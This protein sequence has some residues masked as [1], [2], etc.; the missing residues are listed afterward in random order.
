MQVRISLLLWLL[1]YTNA[2]DSFPLPQVRI[3]PTLWFQVQISVAVWSLWFNKR[4]YILVLFLGRFKLINTW[5]SV[6]IFDLFY[7]FGHVGL[8]NTGV[9]QSY[10]GN[11]FGY[12][13]TQTRMT[14][15]LCRKCVSNLLSGFKCKSVLLFG[16]FGLINVS[17][18]WSCFSGALG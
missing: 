14:L 1:W 10:S 13:G 5:T 7:L 3:K 12:F 15:F 2:H 18:Y 11:F 6:T 16:H 8:V 4:K 9:Y 17:A